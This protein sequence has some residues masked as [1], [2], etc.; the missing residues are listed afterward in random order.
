[1]TTRALF[2]SRGLPP[3][4]EGPAPDPHPPPAAPRSLPFYEVVADLVEPDAIFF[5]R[6]KENRAHWQEQMVAAEAAGD[7]AGAGGP[8][9]RRGTQIAP[10]LSTER[11]AREAKQLSSAATAAAAAK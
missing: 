3:A 10:S 5:T 7:G 9:S 1:M 4:A 2:S 6:L 11:L 8:G